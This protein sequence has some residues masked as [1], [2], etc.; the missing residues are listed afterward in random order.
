MLKTAIFTLRLSRTVRYVYQ[1][2]ACSSL[3]AILGMRIAF[4]WSWKRACTPLFAIGPQQV[5]F[6]SSRSSMSLSVSW[7]LRYQYTVF[8]FFKCDQNKVDFTFIIAIYSPLSC[9]FVAVH[10]LVPSSLSRY[11]EILFFR[12]HLKIFPTK[13]SP[14]VSSKIFLLKLTL[15]KYIPKLQLKKAMY[16]TTTGIK[17]SLFRNPI[18]T[19]WFMSC[20]SFSSIPGVLKHPLK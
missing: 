6:C 10:F 18:G 5:L 12:N 19:S 20:K 3:I 16:P 15:N 11:H 9:Q 13:N 1:N 14:K 8:R 7:I 17:P 4:H 2:W